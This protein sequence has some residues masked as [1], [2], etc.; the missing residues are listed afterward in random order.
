MSF[1]SNFYHRALIFWQD[2][3]RKL[4][5]NENLDSFDLQNWDEKEDQ[6]I[7]WSCENWNYFFCHLFIRHFNTRVCASGNCFLARITLWRFFWLY[8]VVT[9]RVTA[10]AV[11]R[12]TTCSGVSLYSW[13]RILTMNWIYTLLSVHGFPLRGSLHKIMSSKNRN[14]RIRTLNK[15]LTYSGCLYGV[16]G[17]PTMRRNDNFSAEVLYL[18]FLRQSRKLAYLSVEFVSIVHRHS[19]NMNDSYFDLLI[20]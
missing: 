18:C 16:G 19:I 11:F 7:L 9:A 8:A 15:A 17:W 14:E 2:V 3:W 5:C 6:P 10:K 20:V 13:L 12:L 1:P 4:F